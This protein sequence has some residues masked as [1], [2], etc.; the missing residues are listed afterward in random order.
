MADATSLGGEP[1]ADVRLHRARHGRHH[2]AGGFTTAACI[3][4]SRRRRRAG[5]R[6]PGGRHAPPRPR[7]SSR[8]IWR[9]RPRSSSRA[10]HRRT[11]GTARAVVVNSGCA[12]ACTGD[13]GPGPCRTM[14]EENG[15]G[16]R[17]RAG[18]GAG[19]G[20]RRHWRELQID[21]VV[22]GIRAA[23]RAMARGQGQRRGARHHDH[24][25]VSQGTRGDG[26]DRTGTFTVGGM[27]KGSG[28]IEPNM[29][30][31][32]GFLTTDAQV[33]PALLRQA[34][35][36]RR[37]TRSTPSPSTASARRTMRCSPWP[38][39]RAAWPS[40]R[41]LIR[42]CSRGSSTVSRELGAWD[43]P[44]RRGRDEAH[45]RDRARRAHE[46]RRARWRG[47]L[48]IRRS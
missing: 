12:N 33:P 32:L 40:T 48:P 19:G 4:A 20:N 15:G 30:T 5:P 29:A 46:R 31:M 3:A 27:A 34:L 7:R 35:R 10:A 16:G 41:L 14:A 8:R 11:R 36:R 25:S 9:R 22:A 21:R 17:L 2:G 43:R 28:M 38:P 23:A 13:A 1:R 47:P 39:A 45:C 26:A 6:G 18:G 37:G 44:R 24:R 42:R